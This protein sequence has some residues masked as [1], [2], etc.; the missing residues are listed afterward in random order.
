MQNSVPGHDIIVIGASAGGVEALSQLVAGLPTR[1]KASVF[2]VLHVP[3][4]STSALPRILSVCGPLPVVHATDHLRIEQGCIY[5][6][7]PDY[8]LLLEPGQMRVVKGPKENRHRPA[9]DPLFRSAAQAYGPRVIGVILT[10]SLNDGTSGL[11]AVKQR[12]GIAVVQDPAEAHFP[13][14][15]QSAIAYAPVDYV[16]PLSQMAALLS[17]LVDKR[18]AEDPPGDAPRDMSNEVSRAAMEQNDIND[19]RMLETPTLYT[20]PECG[21]ALW[22]LHEGNLTHF[23]CRI[24]HA[25]TLE[26]LLAQ[27]DETLE[28]ALWRTRNTLEEQANLTERLIEQTRQ[29]SHEQ[30]VTRLEEKLHQIRQHLMLLAQVLLEDEEDMQENQTHP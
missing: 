11:W 12:G 17:R 1:L 20:C 27:Q 30:K 19:Q 26:A 8:H 15:P 21:G 4:E 10:G 18:A 22:E 5:V 3:A 24:G 25:Y 9:V 7:P 6:A 28:A 2:V 23:R 14:M 16:V 29:H 13:S